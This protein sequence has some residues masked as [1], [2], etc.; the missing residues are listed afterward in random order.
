MNS[1]IMH[2]AMNSSSCITNETQYHCI[3]LKKAISFLRKSMP[4]N[5]IERVKFFN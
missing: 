2:L 5:K 4:E 3:V 1:L